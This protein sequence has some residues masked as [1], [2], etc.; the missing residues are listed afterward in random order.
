MISDTP[1]SCKTGIL[2]ASSRRHGGNVGKLRFLAAFPSA[3][4]RQVPGPLDLIY[5]T[6]RDLRASFPRCGLSCQ[7]LFSGPFAVNS[8]LS[9]VSPI[10]WTSTAHDL[11]RD[12]PLSWRSIRCVL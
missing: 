11:L 10:I 7:L 4:R 9:K 2:L 5:P 3:M 1:R 12:L 6:S 8:Y